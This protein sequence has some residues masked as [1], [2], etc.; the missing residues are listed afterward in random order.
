MRHVVPSAQRSALLA[1]RARGHRSS[2]TLSEARLW[3]ELSAGGLGVVFRRQVPVGGRFI[4]DF[5][6]PALRLIVEVDGSAHVHK[7]RADARRNEKLRRLGYHVLRLEASVVLRE[8]EAAV[9]AVRAAVL[10]LR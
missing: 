9:A 5:L 7:R 8:P 4:A 10:R 1:A 6:A 2:P 3:R